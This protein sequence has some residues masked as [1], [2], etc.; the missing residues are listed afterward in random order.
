VFQ[1][2]F[3]AVEMATPRDRIGSGN[4]AGPL[5]RGRSFQVSKG[6]EDLVQKMVCRSVDRL[7]AVCRGADLRFCSGVERESAKVEFSS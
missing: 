1:N 3:E 4:G 5:L 6:L 7:N 2:Q